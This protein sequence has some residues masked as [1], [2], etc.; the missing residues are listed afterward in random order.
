MNSKLSIE[1]LSAAAGWIISWDGAR[2]SVGGLTSQ[3][4]HGTIDKVPERI[5]G[6]FLLAIGTGMI[7]PI[8]DRVFAASDKRRGI[9][10]EI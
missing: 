6:L 3:L 1:I 5:F 2:V 10:P 7:L 9:S 8:M 4:E